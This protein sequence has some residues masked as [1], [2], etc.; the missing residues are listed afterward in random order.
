MCVCICS[1]VRSLCD[2]HAWLCWWRCRADDIILQ[3][4]D[5]VLEL[6]K[7]SDAVQALKDSTNTVVLVSVNSGLNHVRLLCVCMHLIE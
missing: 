7:H 2:M 6:V 5:T 1:H 3:V 4:N